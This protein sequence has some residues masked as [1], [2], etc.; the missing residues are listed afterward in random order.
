E[1]TRSRGAVAMP[2]EVIAMPGDSRTD[3][4]WYAQPEVSR[5]VDPDEAA[6]Q[7]E[8]DRLQN[9][10]ASVASMLLVLVASLLLFMGAWKM[11]QGQEMLW[12]IIP[13][14]GFHELGHYLAMR[15]FGYRNLRMFFI[16]FF[17][18]AVSG[19]HY[20]V[21]GWKKVIVAVAG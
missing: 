18:A 5:P 10:Q 19:R 15:W 2:V 6:V 13:I 4:D 12:T 21:P 1:Q 8:L 7:V 3:R 9:Q 11:G 20:N 16:P 17:G 14:L